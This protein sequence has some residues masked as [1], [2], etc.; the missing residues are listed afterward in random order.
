M[1][2]YQ[3]PNSLELTYNSKQQLNNKI[4][5]LLE[6]AP[7]DSTATSQIT[8]T[9]IGY[10]GVL[11]LT[12]CQG[13]FLSVAKGRNLDIMVKVLLRRMYRRLKVWRNARYADNELNT[14]TV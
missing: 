7:C 12:S 1:K 5:Q 9:I 14:M 10:R 3:V 11:R 6:V 8:E 13:I 2:D 4:N